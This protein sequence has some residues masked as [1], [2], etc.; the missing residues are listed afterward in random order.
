[1]ANWTDNLI[2]RTFLIDLTHPF[3]K[4]FVK[5]RKKLEGHWTNTYIEVDPSDLLNHPLFSFYYYIQHTILKARSKHVVK[6]VEIHNVSHVNY[7]R[8]D[9]NA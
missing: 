3:R 2:D 9:V 6:T 5:L 1:M 8:H 4:A 7:T